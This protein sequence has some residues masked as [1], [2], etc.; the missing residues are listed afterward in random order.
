VTGFEICPDC[1]RLVAGEKV[2]IGAAEFQRLTALAKAYEL[3]TQRIRDF[4][5]RSH[6]PI[7]RQPDLAA[8]ILECSASLTLHQ[9]AAACRLKF[10]GQTPS[11]SAIARF[12]KVAQMP[13]EAGPKAIQPA[14]SHP[15]P[16]TI[17]KS[18]QLSA[19][20]D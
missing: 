6:S 5:R 2:T 17:A 8:F 3:A 18:R 14:A 4:H 11:K 12:L 15:P 20:P 9:T 10:G 16:Q 1:G 7:A 13:P 19:N